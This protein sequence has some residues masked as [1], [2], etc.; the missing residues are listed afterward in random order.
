[1]K[2]TTTFFLLIISFTVCSQSIITGTIS[3]ALG[4]L[5]EANIVIKNSALGV[6][7][8]VEG[9]FEIPAKPLDTLIVSYL[10]YTTKV[11]AIAN[12]KEHIHLKLEGQV[13]LDEVVVVAYGTKTR[14][15]YFSCGTVCVMSNSFKSDVITEKLYPNPSKNGIFHL[16]FLNPFTQLEVQV[17]NSSGELIKTSNYQNMS[18]QV[19]IDLSQY[20]PGIYIINIIA[21]GKRLLPK[22]A[23][24]G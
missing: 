23:I 5:E 8:N 17:N 14:C 9:Y 24:R 13:A 4:P 19:S 10:G 12:Q 3:D 16:Q 21:D 15:C 20:P 18:Q 6:V 1:M 11:V 2:L 22:K 7:S